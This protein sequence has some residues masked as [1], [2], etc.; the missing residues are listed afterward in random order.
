MTSS[1][2]VNQR[3]INFQFLDCT[4]WDFR[5]KECTE[6]FGH[7]P[8]L[9]RWINVYLN[10]FRWVFV[11]SLHWQLEYFLEALS[12]HSIWS[13]WGE[14]GQ[15][16]EGFCGVWMCSAVPGIWSR[17][18]EW[19]WCH[20]ETPASADGE[21]G[22]KLLEGRMYPKGPYWTLILLYRS[23]QILMRNTGGLGIL[24]R[25]WRVV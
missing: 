4:W 8:S 3:G 1:L 2:K 7:V 24:I 12:S 16:M 14:V 13:P 9:K 18:L 17:F 20:S 19:A 15:E 5:E 21:E 22:K 6:N 11:G 10:G 25:R 23:C